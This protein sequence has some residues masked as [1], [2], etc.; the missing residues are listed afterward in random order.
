MMNKKI[1]KLIAD[2]I[3]LGGSLGGSTLIAL[4]IG[5][6]AYGYMLFLLASLAGIYLLMKSDASRS[7]MIVTLYFTGVNF[8]GM[9]RYWS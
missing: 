9:V 5:M 2:A 6:N 4:N 1:K 8:M 3:Y 7:L